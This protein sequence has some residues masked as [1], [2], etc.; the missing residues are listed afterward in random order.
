MTTCNDKFR[1][2]VFTILFVG[3]AEAAFAQGSFQNLD[4]EAAVIS[5]VSPGLIS[6]ADAFPYWTVHLNDTVFSV[7]ST[8]DSFDGTLAVLLSS[9]SGY[10]APLQGYY[11]VQLFGNSA[12]PV[13]QN[14]SI[15]QTGLISE[16]TQSIQFQLRNNTI[17]DRNPASQ[18]FLVTINGTPIPL[19]VQS[20][21]GGIMTLGG[22]VSAFSGTTAELRFTAFDGGYGLDSILFSSQAVPEPSALSL[23]GLGLLGLGW[24]RRRSFR[25]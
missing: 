11:C 23:I 10:H 20:S 5:P 12:T 1:Q 21:T 14:A 19:F 15:S 6:A 2:I 13:Y 17:P 22:N 25:A 24:H 3:V 7:V 9:A 8:D 16:G 4:F 18:E